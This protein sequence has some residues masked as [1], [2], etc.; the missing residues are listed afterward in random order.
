MRDF[1]KRELYEVAASGSDK[2]VDDKLKMLVVVDFFQG[3]QP[4]RLQKDHILFSRKAGKI[5]GLQNRDI[6]LQLLKFLCGDNIVDPVDEIGLERLQD[7]VLDLARER[8]A[9]VERLGLF[10]EA[11]LAAMGATGNEEGD[12][13]SLSVR[14]I[15]GPYRSVVHET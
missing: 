9:V 3:F 13:H 12:S 8:F 4:L 6:A 2:E 10:V 15:A 7:R 5:D 1:D 14:D 11:A